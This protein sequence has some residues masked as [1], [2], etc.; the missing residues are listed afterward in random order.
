MEPTYTT[1]ELAKLAR[2]DR[3]AREAYEKDASVRLQSLLPG[4]GWGDALTGPGI[5]LLEFIIYR[6]APSPGYRPFTTKEAVE[7][8]GKVV[9]Y[10]RCFGDH[11]MIVA[12][13]PDHV[14]LGGLT[15]T[16]PLVTLFGHF[17]FPNGD[18][19]GAI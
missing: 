1:D 8:I 3:E 4:G 12:A 18:P 2:G 19:C 5:D 6:I 10:K 14:M 7:L 9:R 16:V 15:D 11:R 17:E 13:G